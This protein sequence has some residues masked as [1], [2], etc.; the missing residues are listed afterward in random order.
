MISEKK[1][2]EIAEKNS[3]KLS[4]ESIE[5]INKKLLEYALELIN[6]SSRKAEFYGRSVIRL[7]DFEN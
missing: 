7:E 5:I 1:L 4:K 3:K 2:K 6:K